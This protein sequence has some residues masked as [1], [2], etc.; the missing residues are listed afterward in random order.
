MPTFYLVFE[1]T[2]DKTSWRAWVADDAMS[3][4]PA[5]RRLWQADE[6]DPQIARSDQRRSVQFDKLAAHSAEDFAQLYKNVASPGGS[7]E[8]ALRVL[9]QD[10]ALEKLMRKAVLAAAKRAGELAE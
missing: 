7:T 3:D 1:E 5:Q 9:T 4:P 8:A 6:S 2:T 10:S